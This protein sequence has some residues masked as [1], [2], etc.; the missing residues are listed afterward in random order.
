ME[1]E[2]ESLNSHNVWEIID[3]LPK[4]KTVKSKWVYSIKN[5]PKTKKI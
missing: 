2:F 1:N 3:K 4:I 5:D